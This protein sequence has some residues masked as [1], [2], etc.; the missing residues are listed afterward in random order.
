M[1]ARLPRELRD[2]IYEELLHDIPTI[3]N[4]SDLKALKRAL[5]APRSRGIRPDGP[6]FQNHYFNKTCMGVDFIRELMSVYLRRA[7]LQVY[8]HHLVGYF[9]P[10]PI[11]TIDY[12]GI[13]QSI[14]ELVQHV[15]FV[16]TS[17]PPP[18]ILEPLLAISNMDCIIELSMPVPWVLSNGNERWSS[19]TITKQGALDELRS[20]LRILGTSSHCVR[21]RYQGT[22][23]STI[24]AKED[25]SWCGP[26]E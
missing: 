20:S 18:H 14:G 9:T 3:F 19:A 26:V 11:F 13:G 25:F 17:K 2:A 5:T 16:V 4:F 1:F 12:F 23:I 10:T 21:M 22:I 8:A 24:N 6:I 15:E 7:S